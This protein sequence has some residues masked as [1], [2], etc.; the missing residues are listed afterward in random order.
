MRHTLADDGVDG[1]ASLVSHESDDREDDEAREDAGA[2]VEEGN[3]E[4]VPE[5]IT[6]K[7]NRSA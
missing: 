5:S 1:R 6:C 2:A 7:F 3:D 4:R